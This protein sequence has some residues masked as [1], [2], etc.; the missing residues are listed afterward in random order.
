MP[1]ISGI[2][3]TKNCVLGGLPFVEALMSVA[4]ICDEI[5]VANDSTDST[6]KT[7]EYLSRHLPI[8]VI[9]KPWPMHQRDGCLA[10]AT[11]WAL[12]AVE[13]PYFISVQADEIF[14]ENAIPVIKE[15]I[16]EDLRGTNGIQVKRLQLRHNFQEEHGTHYVTRVGRTGKVFASGDALSM[17]VLDDKYINYGDNYSLFDITRCFI[18]NYPGKSNNQAEIW[19]H[20]PNRNSAGWFNKT[21]EQWQAQIEEWRDV[22]FPEIYT[23]EKGPFYNILPMLMKPWVGITKW[24]PLPQYLTQQNIPCLTHGSNKEHKCIQCRVNSL[25]DSGDIK[26]CK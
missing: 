7:L 26:L 18:E 20:L 21:P 11:Q 12:D 10:T 2:C 23:R 4:P 13:N 9:D 17:R 1:K 19:S 8:K 5:I 3:I 16:D 25:I 15:M 24:A 6:T 22:G 14:H